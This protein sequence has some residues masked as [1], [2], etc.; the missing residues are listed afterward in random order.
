MSG[1]ENGAMFSAPAQTSGEP[2]ESG[3]GVDVARLGVIITLAARRRS[4]G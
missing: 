4:Y 1:N 3:I 2:N